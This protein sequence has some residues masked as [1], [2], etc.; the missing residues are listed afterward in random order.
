MP[1]CDESNVLRECEALLQGVPS[2]VA[3]Y[4]TH[5]VEEGRGLNVKEAKALFNLDLGS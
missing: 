4:G 3:Y 2:S 5:R 1:S